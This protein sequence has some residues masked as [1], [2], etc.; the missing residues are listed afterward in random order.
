MIQE[1]NTQAILPATAVA[2]NQ[3]IILTNTNTAD[4]LQLIEEPL[5]QPAAGEV[6]VRVT[7]SG[8][9]FADIMCRQGMYPTMPKLPFTPGYDCVGSVDK[10]GDG[11]ADLKTGQ[12]VGALL[13][14]FGAN[15]N[16]I[17]VPAPLLV[18][19]PEEI[20]P[21]AGTAV[22]LN[23][24]TAHRLLTISAKAQPGERI[25]VHS[26]A[27]G[28]G[29]AVLQIGKILGLD[30]YGTASAGKLDLVRSL[31]ATAIDYKNEDFA[32]RMRVLAPEGI[33]IVI[34][35]VGGKTMQQSYKLLRSGGRLVSSC[36]MSAAGGGTRAILP[37][38][39][40]LAWY[41]I[42]PDGKK[43]FFF[44]DTPSHAQKDN[45]W[46]R[47]TLALLFAWLSDGR[48]QPIIGAKFPLAETAKAQH[49]LE[50][51]AVQGKII[52]MHQK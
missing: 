43:G 9:A 21:A 39:G 17:C 50:T 23:Y 2:T 40:R 22:I 28:V 52:L 14:K 33:D 29:T 38:F 13:P 6:R 49:M 4:A 37:N 48:I 18:P 25:L 36:F 47:E 16:Y 42:W 31:G 24:L 26:A 20:D 46:Y 19:M 41:G 44:G 12:T 7:A 5:P 32:E 34:D 27:G 10:L 3:R 11:V 8:V 1:M 51:G 35:P 45:A 15:A 30:M